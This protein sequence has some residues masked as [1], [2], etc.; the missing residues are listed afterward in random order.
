MKKILSIIATSLLWVSSAEAGVPL[1]QEQGNSRYTI[2]LDSI[3]MTIDANGGKI[4]SFRY[5][6][7]EAISQLKWPN[8]F[9][10]TFWTSP[11]KE[12]YR[13]PIPEYDKLPYTVKQENSSLVMTS[14]ISPTQQYQITKQ[15]SA[16]PTDDA[17]IVSYTITN[18]SPLTRQAAP[19][20]IT[21]VINDGNGLIFF[22]ADLS[23]IT[24]ARLMNFKAADGAVWYQPD[25]ADQNRKINADGKGWLAYYNHGLLLLK[26]FQDLDVS[27]PAPEEAEIQVYVNRGKTYIELESQGAYTTLEPDQ[28]LTWTVRWYLRRVNGD[29]TLPLLLEAIK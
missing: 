11:Q 3:S 24:P 16:D 28:S 6:N 12:W 18:K 1:I 21:R 7:Q 2:Q 15:F 14:Q 9:G 10:S 27:Q 20:E 4:L 23:G 17:V 5:G 13:P 22:D 8:A 25:V 26:K 29:P 19:W